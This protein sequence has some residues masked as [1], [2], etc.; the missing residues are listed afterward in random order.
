MTKNGKALAVGLIIAALFAYAAHWAMGLLIAFAALYQAFRTPEISHE[1][2]ESGKPLPDASPTPGTTSCYDTKQEIKAIPCDITGNGGYDFEVVGESHYQDEIRWC[3]PL[4]YRMRDKVRLYTIAT[5]YQ[6]DDNE[7]DPNAV[8]VK[9]DGET[10]GYLPRDEA[11]HFRR[12]ADK[13]GLDRKSTCR[14]VIVGGEG[15]DYSIWLDLPI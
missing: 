3:L 13:E 2:G 9:I 7:H 1:P 10:V 5:L 4:S 12:W 6:D 15:K 14:A 8:A 11:K